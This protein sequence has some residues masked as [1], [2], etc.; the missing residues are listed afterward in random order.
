MSERYFGNTLELVAAQNPAQRVVRVAQRDQFGP[1]RHECLQVGDVET[2]FGD[3]PSLHDSASSLDRTIE[4]KIDRVGDDGLITRGGENR[5]GCEKDR[6][7]STVRGEEC[8][9][10]AGNVMAG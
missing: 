8:F 1:P 5:S 6:G 3:L 2:P 7:C 4:Q 9:G 10:S